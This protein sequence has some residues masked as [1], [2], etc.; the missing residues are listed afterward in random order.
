MI[1]LLCPSSRCWQFLCV[2]YRISFRPSSVVVVVFA[3]LPIGR[4]AGLACALTVVCRV[5]H[6]R[7]RPSSGCCLHTPSSARLS[8]RYPRSPSRPPAFRRASSPRS[9]DH[10]R[11]NTKRTFKVVWWWG[12]DGRDVFVR[13]CATTP[14]RIPHT[15]ARA[16]T[17]TRTHAH[18][19]T[20]THTHTN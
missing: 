6:V 11:E 15:R 9:V 13:H 3:L 8:I 12:V 16:H 14:Y 10:A 20:H 5:S 7:R 4:L 17:H 2:R 19:H 1:L 18:T